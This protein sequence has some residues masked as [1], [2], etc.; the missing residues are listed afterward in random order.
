MPMITGTGVAS[1]WL[2]NEI[3][4]YVLCLIQY[5]LS[6]CYGYR[7]SFKC[8]LG[9][10][11]EP[12]T[13][14]MR[15]NVNLQWQCHGVISGRARVTLRFWDNRNSVGKVCSAFWVIAPYARGLW[16]QCFRGIFYLPVQIRCDWGED[17]HWKTDRIVVTQSWVGEW[18]VCRVEVCIR[19]SEHGTV[20]K[21]FV[22]TTVDG[23]E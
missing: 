21:L 15:C 11:T 20:T 19:E 14:V 13:S 17:S 22:I 10:G 5:R 7:L 1:F 9:D 4:T 18:F 6:S 3:M 2:G 16:Y 8:L 23:K 12:W